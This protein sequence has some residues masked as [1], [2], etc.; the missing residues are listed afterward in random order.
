MNSQNQPNK[1]PACGAHNDPGV[2]NLPDDCWHCQA[3]RLADEKIMRLKE[4]FEQM[5]DDLGERI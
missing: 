3:V 1:C 2:D 5:A 4:R